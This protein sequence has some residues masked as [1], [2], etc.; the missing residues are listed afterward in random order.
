MSSK[1]TKPSINELKGRA[2]K[3]IGIAPTAKQPIVENDAF[4]RMQKLA[5]II[6]S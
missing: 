5:G 2:S 6:K 1:M 3:A 4:A